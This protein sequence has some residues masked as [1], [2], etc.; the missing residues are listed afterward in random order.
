MWQ[1]I[2]SKFGNDSIEEASQEHRTMGFWAAIALWFGANVVVTTIFTGML[3]VP[4]VPYLTALMIILLGSVVGVAILA[5]VGNVGTRTGL[6]TMVAS[7]G[8]FGIRGSYIPAFV[9]TLVLIGWSWIQ[10]YMAGLSLNYAVN[11]TFGYSNVALFAVVCE[12][13]V[14]LIVLRGHV[15]IESME[16]LVAL[17][18]VVLAGAVFYKLFSEFSVGDIVGLPVEARNGITTAIAFDIVVATAFSWMVLAADFNR[19][20]KSERGGMAGTAIGYVGGTVLAMGLGATVSGFSIARGLEQTYDPTALLAGFGFGLP[21]AI[22]VFLSVM[23]TNVMAVYGAVLS[24]MNIRPQ[25]GFWKP[26]LAIGVIT[27]LGSTSEYIFNNFQSF[28]LILG[29]LFIPVFAIFL[30]D[31]FIVKRGRYDVRDILEHNGGGAY[32]YTAGFNVPACVAYVVGAA[33]A[34]YWTQFSPLS[35]GSS[36]PVFFLTIFLYLAMNAVVSR[37]SSSPVPTSGF[38]R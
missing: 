8:A 29:S 38:R 6:S 37:R 2:V 21:A 14:V 20:A 4:D 17:V 30:A 36:L 31:Y 1:R 7:R 26:A 9:N 16:K 35:F 23:T 12:V 13:I 15:G 27:V 10:A 5:L 28:L 11:Y 19:N 25:D 33:L 32:W 18:M 22:V 24:Y 34:L 3:F